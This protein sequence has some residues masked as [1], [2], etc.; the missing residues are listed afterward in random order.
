MPAMNNQHSTQLER[1]IDTIGLPAVLRLL[2]EICYEKSEH[3]ATNWQ[4]K[5]LADCWSS[6]GDAV[7]KLADSR[8]ITALP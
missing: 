1:L 3:V 4:D 8:H 7:H 6:A 5:A 2:G